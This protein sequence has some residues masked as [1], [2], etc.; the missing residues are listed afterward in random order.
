M[1]N[2]SCYSCQIVFELWRKW[3]GLNA[4]NL[5]SNKDD[6]HLLRIPDTTWLILFMTVRHKIAILAHC[7]IVYIAKD[8]CL[9]L[10]RNGCCFGLT[11]RRSR[12]RNLQ[13]LIFI[14]WSGKIK[15]VH[16]PPKIEK[17]K[18]G[19]FSSLSHAKNLSLKVI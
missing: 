14:M 19:S 18:L 9:S 1:F 4:W 11:T 5:N 7:E 15:N 3:Q 17:K 13:G 2:D 16:F 12:V 8:Y 6:G 10:W